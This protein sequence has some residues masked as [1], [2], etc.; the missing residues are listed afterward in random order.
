ME[1]LY[2]KTKII[3]RVKKYFSPYIEMLTK[4]TGRKLFLM[5]L[6]M[7]SMQAV[8]SIA[9][10]YKWFLRPLAK[11]SLN[12]YYH[13]LSYAELPLGK[14]AEVTLR[15]A[16][17]LIDEKTAKL[18]VLLLIDDTLQAKFGTKFECYTTIYDHA[19]HNGTSYLKGHCFV[20]LAVCVPVIIG[21]G[22]KYLSVPL[23]FR[24]KGDDESKLTIA[25]AMITDAM[26]TLKDIPTVILMCDSW[27][28]KG[29]VLETV[30]SHSNLELIANVRVDTVIYDLPQP[31]GKRGRPAKK[32]KKLSIYDD[33]VFTQVGKYFIAARTVITNLF[34]NPVYMTV[35]AT[36]LDIHMGYRLFLSTCAH[37]NLYSLFS[38]PD[39]SP[40]HD[41]ARVSWLLPLRLYSLR[42]NIEVVFYELKTFWSFGFYRLRSKLGIEIFVNLLAISYSCAKLIPFSDSFFADFSDFSPQ[43]TKFAFADAIRKELFFAN[44]V[45][46]IETHH[47]SLD[48]LSDLDIF[49]FFDRPA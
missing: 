31:T 6:A 34:K 13:M 17:G 4:P 46:F 33:F 15:L 8:T 27:Y 18:P 26:K 22:V 21:N 20:A 29:A 42:W 36:N 37:D 10:I 38:P 41:S 43:T 45:D 28:P 11:I 9:H 7:L 25:S 24:L 48:D 47:I 32:G 30:Q 12:S 5:L 19:R 3:S 16:V 44:F 14:F 23:R 39:Q 2:Q 1:T 35:T 40:N 49:D